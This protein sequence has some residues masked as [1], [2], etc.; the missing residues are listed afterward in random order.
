MRP[1]VGLQAPPSPESGT[2]KRK[3]N[4]TEVRSDVSLECLP[5]RTVEEPRSV[6]RPRCLL[7][8]SQTPRRPFDGKT[9]HDLACQIGKALLQHWEGIRPGGPHAAGANLWAD[10]RPNPPIRREA[11]DV[12]CHLYL[13]IIA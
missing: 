9:L 8:I 12:A 4:G 13:G 11:R 3:T 10:L 5:T 6:Q 7:Q 1:W 2:R